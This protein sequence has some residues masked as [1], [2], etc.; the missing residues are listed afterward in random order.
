MSAFVLVTTGRSHGETSV[1]PAEVFEKL[2]LLLLSEGFWPHG[3]QPLAGRLLE[4]GDV[5]LF[6]LVGESGAEIVGDA[7]VVA[8]SQPLAP[9]HL[10][11]VHMYLGHLLPPDPGALTHAVALDE[12]NI[13]DEGSS[14]AE[15]EA[16]IAEALAAA[17]DAGQTGALRPVHCLAHEEPT[18]HAA[19]IEAP[20]QEETSPERPLPPPHGCDAKPF[21]LANWELV[22]FGEPLRPV[23]GNGAGTIE[24]PAGPVDVICEGR[25]PSDVVAVMWANGEPPDQLLADVRERLAW[26]R[27]HVGQEGGSVRGLILTLDG[28]HDLASLDDDLEVRRL[29]LWYEP[30]TVV[31]PL[32]PD[33]LAVA[34]NI[35]ARSIVARAGRV[36]GQ[37]GPSG[38]LDFA[39]KCLRVPRARG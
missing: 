20:A 12:V 22:D 13:W 4:P 27:A 2:M 30:V 3:D 11:H 25:D 7:R 1:A 34:T 15:D 31:R 17:Q 23:K 39:A 36:P 16:L 32:E 5:V 33:P 14:H 24:T 18:E 8:P 19:D 26:L 28:R 38:D 21:I 9:Q 29:R 6:C 35:A 10:A 37:F